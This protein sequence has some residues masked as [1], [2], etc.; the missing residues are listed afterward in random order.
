[1]TDQLDLDGLER[2]AKAATPGD[3]D[4]VPNPPTEYGGHSTGY[5]ECPACGG[6]G[7]VEGETY[8]NFDGVAL[9]VQFF[10]I[11]NG[12][13]NYEAFFRAAN[14]ATILALISQAREAE[15]MRGALDSAGRILRNE[16]VSKPLRVVGAV[17][18]IDQTLAPAAGG[19]E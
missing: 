16:A 4:T 14:P 8:C 3:L 5:F 18:V 10:G 6:E 9:G 13:K 19:G 17:A 15:R 7:E 11:G 12:H 2:L 1:M